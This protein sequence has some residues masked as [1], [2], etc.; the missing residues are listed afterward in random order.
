MNVC[1]HARHALVRTC[2]RARLL[3]LCRRACACAYPCKCVR[4]SMR[5]CVCARMCGECVRVCF[6]V[7]KH[8]EAPRN[9]T[10]RCNKQTRQVKNQV[11]QGL[12]GTHVHHQAHDKRNLHCRPF[13]L[14]QMWC[15][16]LSG[17]DLHHYELRCAGEHWLSHPHCVSLVWSP[18]GEH[19]NNQFKHFLVQYS[20]RHQQR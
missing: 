14:L 4:L 7:G 16:I 3:H 8:P 2:M 12:G 18:A 19:R 11:R 6:C 1:A 20:T 15:W 13:H 5:A 9:K 10:C 17:F